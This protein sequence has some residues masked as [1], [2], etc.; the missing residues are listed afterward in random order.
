MKKTVV[1]VVVMAILGVSAFASAANIKLGIDNIGSYMHLFKEKRAGL[2]TNPT[3]VDSNL[4]STIDVMIASGVKLT[5]LYG[6]EHGVRGNFADGD[7][8][9][10]FIDDSTKLPVYS[11]YGK[12]Y[13]PTAEMLKDVD[14]LCFD[15]QDVGARFYTFIS[16]MYYAMVACKE[17]NK[18]FV[19][20]D[21]P[22][23][24]GGMVEGAVTTDKSLQGFTSIG[25]LPTRHGMT[26]GELA[27]MMNS[28]WGIGCNLTVIPMSGYQRNMLWADTGLQWI[29]PSPNIPSATTA[30]VYS[31]IGFFEAT[32][33]SE[34]RGLTKPFLISGAPWLNAEDYALLLNIKKLPGAQFR[35]AYFTPNFS[36]Y[37]GVMCGGVEVFVTDPQKFRAVAVGLAMV[38][39]ARDLGADKFSY[40]K[41]EKAGGVWGIDVMT[42][43]S[44]L[45]E[46]KLSYPEI[47]AAWDKQAA[48]FKAMSSKYY[49][50]R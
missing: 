32:N 43:D 37:Q 8:I 45:R 33:V 21:R 14:V 39:T 23:P 4:K 25:P 20:F 40:D 29:N 46:N 47:L 44:L 49:L 30:L 6:P 17:Q 9:T 19:V 48:D 27:L 50:Y 11:L 22:N 24:C 26:V 42:G 41:P 1:A 10:T 38:I 5:A 28:E 18:T 2:I 16:T 12:T 31:G 35:P 13:K 34:G 3:G 7:K 36:K 15:I